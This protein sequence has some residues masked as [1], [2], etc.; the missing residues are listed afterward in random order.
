M[1]TLAP[2]FYNTLPTNQSSSKTTRITKFVVIGRTEN[3]GFQLEKINESRKR[4]EFFFSW[5]KSSKLKP[6]LHSTANPQTSST[7]TNIRGQRKPQEM[8]RQTFQSGYH[9]RKNTSGNFQLHRQGREYSFNHV[10][11]I[12]RRR[13]RSETPR[14]CHDPRKT[15]CISPLRF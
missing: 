15:H 14:K 7:T 5:L 12:P 10:R 13:T 8:A 6:V 2:R 4:C 3:P 1:E 11:W 9:R